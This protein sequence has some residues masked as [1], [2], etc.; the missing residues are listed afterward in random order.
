M[1]NVFGSK[2]GLEEADQVKDSI[3]KQWMGMGPKTKTF[4]ERMAKRLGAQD[5]MLVDSGSNALYLGLTMMNLPKGSEVIV[6]SLTWVSCAQAV[7]LA[8][9]KPVFADCDIATQNVTA[10]TIKEQITKDTSAIMVVH[11]GGLACEMDEIMA[12]GLPV[13]EDAC[14]AIDSTYKGKAL[15]TIGDVGVYSFDA[16]KNL[17]IGEGGGVTSTHKDWMERARILR[18]C[19]IGKS[20]FEASTHG[21]DRWWEY[22]IVE[23]FIKMNPSD[24]AAGIGLAQLEKLD[25]NQAIRKRI[26]DRYQKEFADVKEIDIPVDANEGDKHSYFTYFIRIPNRDKVAKY[27]FDRGIYTTLRYHPLHMNAVYNSKQSLPVCEELNETGLNIPLHPSL[28]DKDVDKI[29]NEIKG[30]AELRG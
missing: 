6:P 15:G 29:V 19:G 28:T 23:P 25:E 24:I 5:F 27:L 16:V 22:N 9:C 10:E 26:W 18:Y 21:K 14:H 7:L 1:I 30:C 17:A 13:I 3:E 12:L 8:G 11:Y 2:V 20:G 4:E